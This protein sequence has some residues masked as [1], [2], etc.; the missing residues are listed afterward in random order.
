MRHPPT[1]GANIRALFLLT[2]QNG[3]PLE[4]NAT[5]DGPASK[6]EHRQKCKP[7]SDKNLEVKTKIQALSYLDFCPFS[8]LDIPLLHRGDANVHASTPPRRRRSKGRRNAWGQEKGLWVK[9]DQEEGNIK[10]IPVQSTSDQ[11]WEAECWRFYI[12]SYNQSS[13]WLR[14]SQLCV[15]LQV[16]SQL[17][18][19]SLAGQCSFST[20]WCTI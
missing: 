7:P 10:R 13:P 18:K 3:A 1:P 19:H 6:T 17:Y 14:N 11:Y 5:L 2:Q 8:L 12:S 15:P 16:V 20:P 9:T 4:H